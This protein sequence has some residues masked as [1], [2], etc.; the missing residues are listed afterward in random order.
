[1]ESQQGFLQGPQNLRSDPSRHGLQE[2]HA[3]HPGELIAQAVDKEML[4]A[5]LKVILTSC[6]LQRAQLLITTTYV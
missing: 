6:K 1:M 2:A 3:N 4:P 5:V